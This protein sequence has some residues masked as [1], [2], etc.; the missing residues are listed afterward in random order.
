MMPS[1]SGTTL[2]VAGQETAASSAIGRLTTIGA[3]SST[4]VSRCLKIGKIGAPSARASAAANAWSSSAREALEKSIS[5]AMSVAPA[6][7]SLSTRSP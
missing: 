7:R 6:A 2:T 1:A 3:R 4:W 5:K